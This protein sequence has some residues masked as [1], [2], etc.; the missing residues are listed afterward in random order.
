MR[1]WEWETGS[2][3]FRYTPYTAPRE[4]FQAVCGEIARYYSAR[5]MKYTKSN[6]KLKWQGETLRCEFGLWSSHSNIAGRWVNLDV[7]PTIYAQDKT[8][9]EK[10]GLL[11]F[12]TRLRSFNVY[13]IDEEQFFHIVDFIDGMIEFTRPLQTKEGL[14]AY[15]EEHSMQDFLAKSPNDG[16]YLSRFGLAEP[17]AAEES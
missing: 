2:V 11:Y 1:T 5:G 14:A 9:M 15:F 10:N 16:L 7:I 13:G 12:S 6:R 3:L 4:I 8:D 17:A